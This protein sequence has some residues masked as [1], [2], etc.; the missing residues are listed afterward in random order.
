MEIIREQAVAK[1][2]KLSQIKY[3]SYSARDLHSE[4]P[5]LARVQ[6]QERRR[7][8]EKVMEQKVKLKKD[9]SDIDK[10]LK[11]VDDYNIYMQSAPSDDLGISSVSLM[12]P[13]ILP[14]PTITIGKKPMM[15]RTR[16][17]RRR[18]R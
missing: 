7:Y 11:S 4:R 6:R 12:T 17:P 18:G 15:G 14:K 10:Y 8:M 13:V 3:P 2:G 5:M 16:L 9:I 1:L